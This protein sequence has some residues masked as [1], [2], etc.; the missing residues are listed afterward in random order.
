[1]DLI[2]YFRIAKE[3]LDLFQYYSAKDLKKEK[4]RTNGYC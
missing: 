2:E 3:K 4:R 1:V